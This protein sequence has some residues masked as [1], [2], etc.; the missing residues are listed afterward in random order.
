MGTQEPALVSAVEIHGVLSIPTSCAS[1]P[2]C[3]GLGLFV[4]GGEIRW[5][6]LLVRYQGIVPLRIRLR[7]T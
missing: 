1:R 6:P 7:K 5:L 3:Y 4:H 2:E